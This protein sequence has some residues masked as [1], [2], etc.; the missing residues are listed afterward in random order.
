MKSC[1]TARVMAVVVCAASL[2]ARAAQAAE[3]P[4]DPASADVPAAAAADVPAAAAS[5]DPPAPR[6]AAEIGAGET[7]PSSTSNATPFLYQRAVGHYSPTQS[8]E[9]GATFRANE[10][11]ATPH[12]PGSMFSSG[13][14]VVF[15]GAIDGTYLLNPHFDL[16]LGVNGSP[17]SKRDVA[18]SLQVSKGGTGQTVDAL[19]QTQSSSMGA[20]ASLGY[21]SFD[22][23]QPHDVDVALDGNVAATRFST[24]QAVVAT[25]GPAPNVAPAAATLSQARLGATMTFTILE[26]T[27][28]GVDGAYFLYDA[29]DP[30]NVGLFDATSSGITT[31]VSPSPR[32]SRP[33]TPR[34]DV[35]QRHARLVC[36]RVRVLRS[37]AAHRA[38][39]IA[40]NLARR[41]AHAADLLRKNEDR[42]P[43]QRE[44]LAEPTVAVLRAGRA[45]ASTGNPQPGRF[46]NENDADGAGQDGDAHDDPQRCLAAC[47]SLLLGLLRP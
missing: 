20:V 14:D 28:V 40:V 5:D 32:T 19:V 39:T 7:R 44:A 33:V 27:D 34:W 35:E 21:D 42:R 45:N 36:E 3:S 15:Y 12:T 16:T 41:R 37:N 30:A 47:G 46:P 6:Y 10:G 43:G 11:F 22:E 18:T 38:W 2:I 23:N 13:G 1:V 29:Q 31:V 26:H 25:S 17:S 24:N 8:V 9:L 4:E